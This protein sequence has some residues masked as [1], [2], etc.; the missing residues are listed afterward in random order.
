MPGPLLARS[1]RSPTTAEQGFVF[2]LRVA[3]SPTQDTGG[4]VACILT[5]TTF[6]DVTAPG[7]ALR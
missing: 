4:R 6:I 5:K 3:S 7:S 1:Q 2:R